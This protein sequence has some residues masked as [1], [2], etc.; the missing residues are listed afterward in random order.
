MRDYIFDY[1][2][3]NSELFFKIYKNNKTILSLPDKERKYQGHFVDEEGILHIAICD[4]TTGPSLYK[5]LDDKLI[6]EEV[7]IN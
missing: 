5:F 1:G 7:L 2:Y 3:K 6:L 4:P